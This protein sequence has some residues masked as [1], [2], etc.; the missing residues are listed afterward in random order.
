[1]V[2][3][4]IYRG[5]VL[6]DS[7]ALI[8]LLDDHDQY[9]DYSILALDELAGDASV[10]LF[11][12]NLTLYETYSYLRRHFTWEKANLLWNVIAERIR[13]RCLEFRSSYEEKT[14]EILQLYRGH[15]LSFHD[16]GCA[17][18]M[19]EKSIGRV[20]TFDSDFSIIGFERYP[21]L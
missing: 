4:D 19:I 1:M 12:C 21:D 10:R 8:A 9:H 17:T 3:E 16:A 13:P 7:S 11:I 6:I 14:R 5:Y 18:I 20:F 15:N 2:F